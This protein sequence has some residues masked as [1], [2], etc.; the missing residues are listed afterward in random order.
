MFD[1]LSGKPESILGL[2]S[3]H[4]EIPRY[5][6]PEADPAELPG[7]GGVDAC[8]EPSA[9]A[10]SGRV[11]ALIG[12]ETALT[13]ADGPPPPPVALVLLALIVSQ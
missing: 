9:G 11:P 10:E 1:C 6:L 7:F 8:D 5:L 3:F 2:L 12:V 13:V 4:P